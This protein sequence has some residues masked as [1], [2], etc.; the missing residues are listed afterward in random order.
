MQ[1]NIGHNYKINETQVVSTEERIT[2]EIR[3]LL[4]K[5]S[6][7]E[8]FRYFITLV[9][10]LV[11]GIQDSEVLKSITLSRTKASYMVTDGLGPYFKE[12]MLETIR[13]TQ[14]LFTLLFD[15]TTNAKKLRELQIAIRFF[16]EQNQKVINSNFIY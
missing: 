7:K 9:P 8:S 6:N 13:P 4:Y 3:L 2:A 16:S 14:N 12:Q 10:S 15:E 11:V 1:K 5:L